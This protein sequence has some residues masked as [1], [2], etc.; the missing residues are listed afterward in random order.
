MIYICLLRTFTALVKHQFVA[1]YTKMVEVVAFV[2]QI[3]T[4]KHIER[5]MVGYLYVACKL[6]VAI[7]KMKGKNL[8]TKGKR[9]LQDWD[10]LK[11]GAE[12]PSPR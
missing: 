7:G 10:N 8:P 11:G 9:I 1:P 6:F 4:L 5:F 12:T 3:E 2:I